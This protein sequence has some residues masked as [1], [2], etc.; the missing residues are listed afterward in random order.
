MPNQQAKLICSILSDNTKNDEI[1][2][3]LEH[4]AQMLRN[5]SVNTIKN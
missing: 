5:L 1:K 2:Q 3:N 4:F